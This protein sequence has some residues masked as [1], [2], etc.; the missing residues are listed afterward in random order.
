MGFNHRAAVPLDFNV[1][2]L[3]PQADSAQG[4]DI[5]TGVS[6][7][8]AQL[9]DWIAHLRAH[10]RPDQQTV[11]IIAGFLDATSP[12]WEA[13]S[14]PNT[15]THIVSAGQRI[16]IHCFVVFSLSGTHGG[17]AH[18][19]RLVAIDD[20]G[21]TNVTTAL[22]TYVFTAATIGPRSFHVVHTVGAAGTTRIRIEGQRDAG[23]AASIDI[24]QGS[25]MSVA[26]V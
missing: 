5:P 14:D 3:L 22:G 8:T 21:G 23:S 17:V 15:T 13:V 10:V 11:T 19:L 4:H 25:Q 24:D 6:P 12:A 1:N 20:A 9:Q 26:Y 18:R 2:P 7:T 16:E